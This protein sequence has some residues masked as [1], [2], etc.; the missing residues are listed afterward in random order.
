MYIYPKFPNSFMRNKRLFHTLVFLLTLVLA[1]AAHSPVSGQKGVKL[2]GGMTLVPRDTSG[3]PADG[4][5]AYATGEYRNLFAENNH[6]E[7]QI[8]RRTREAY[9]KLF[10]GDTLTE[11][12]MFRAG[13]NENGPLAYI[14]DVLHNDVRSEGMSYGMMIAV[15]MDRKV[16]F[17]ALWNWAVTHMYVSDPAHPC[18]GYFLRQLRHDGTSISEIPAPDG[19]E[20]MVTALY[21]AHNRWG[22]SEGIYGYKAWADKILTAMRHRAT[23]SGPT[24][25]GLCTVH[26]MVN[27]EHKMI[28]FSPDFREGNDFT[29]PSYH[30]PAFYELWARWGPEAD[31]EFWASAAEASRDFFVKASDTFTGLSSDYA[32]F[33][34][35]PLKASSNPNASNFGWDSW[36]TPS[37]WAVDYA[38]WGKDSRQKELSNRIQAFFFRQELDSYGS[39]YSPDGKLVNPDYRPGLAATLAVTSLAA[40]HYIAPEFVEALWKTPLPL[41]PGQRYYD[42]LLYMMSW[43]HCSGNFRIWTQSQ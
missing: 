30:L 35:K 34:G 17:D 16:D 40:T 24:K 7:E 22:S 39:I 20:Y 19:E 5:G 32:H 27:E 41:D 23:K 12:V 36:R 15:Q 13:G 43:L 11:A 8:A 31:R 9:E 28:R 14:R 3:I 1:G 37:N 42:G 26:A 38:W 6:S 21:F 4:I 2:A 18:E 10:H 29:D 33:D 25:S